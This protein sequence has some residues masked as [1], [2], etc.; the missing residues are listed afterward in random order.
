MTSKSSTTNGGSPVGGSFCDKCDRQPA[1]QYWWED[2][3]EVFETDSE[4]V[5]LC[6]KCYDQ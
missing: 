5:S 1:K 2:V 6:D 4:W 3:K